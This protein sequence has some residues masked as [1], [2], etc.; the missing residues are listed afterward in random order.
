MS[1]SS[2]HFDNLGKIHIFV[3]FRKIIK[4]IFCLLLL[5]W[6]ICE[7]TDYKCIGSPCCLTHRCVEG[8]LF[9]AIF[10]FWLL[11]Q[12]FLSFFDFMV[13]IVCKS[14]ISLCLFQGRTVQILPRLWH[15]CCC[16][17]LFVSKQPFHRMPRILPWLRR[18]DLRV[19][20]QDLHVPLLPKNGRTDYCFCNRHHQTSEENTRI[21]W[22]YT[23][24]TGGDLLRMVPWSV[25]GVKLK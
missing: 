1:T 20:R 19:G 14:I 25:G 15:C 11:M 18:S 16:L 24:V 7:A 22:R 8:V 2:F 21:L 23:C 17:T 10:S 4:D 3:F 5:F 9:V 12:N 6:Q 13:A